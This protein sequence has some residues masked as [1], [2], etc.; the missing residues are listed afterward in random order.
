MEY[1]AVFFTYSGA[2]KYS[3]YLQKKGIK[4]ETTPVPR[5]YTSNCGIGVK[6]FTDAD[7]K[8]LISYDIEKLYRIENGDSILIYQAD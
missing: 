2:I 8:K 5:K 7:I 4:S 1:Y 3:K 6:F